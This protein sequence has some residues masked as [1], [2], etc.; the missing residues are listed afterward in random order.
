MEH[1]HTIMN[2]EI[3]LILGGIDDVVVGENYNL[4]VSGGISTKNTHI[5][6]YILSGNKSK[7]YVKKKLIEW[8]SFKEVY[9]DNGTLDTKYFVNILKTANDILPLPVYTTNFD[10]F[11]YM[12]DT[13]Y[14][15][16]LSKISNA[17][18]NT[19]D[20]YDPFNQSIRFLFMSYKVYIENIIEIF[21]KLRNLHVDLKEIIDFDDLIEKWTYI[22]LENKTDTSSIILFF[23]FPPSVLKL[24]STIP[25]I[26]W[27]INNTKNNQMYK[28][29]NKLI[30]KFLSDIKTLK[31]QYIGFCPHVSTMRLLA[32]L[33]FPIFHLLNA[34][35]ELDKISKKPQKIKNK[36][37]S[38]CKCIIKKIKNIE[39]CMSVIKTPVILSYSK[40][41]VCLQRTKFSSSDKSCQIKILEKY[42]GL[43]LHLYE[44]TLP[45]IS[46]REFLVNKVAISFSE[47][48][49]S[50]QNLAKKIY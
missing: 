11:I 5:N 39:K 40:K 32:I 45:E 9:Y 3:K 14:N 29:Y 2:P 33:K 30:D 24:D 20:I 37:N 17:L 31:F 12:A 23:N 8:D 21:V 46:K 16:D 26:K 25:T 22:D 7:T 19:Y 18:I 42:I 27:K 34:I 15:S 41:K 6:K 47:I 38:K 49:N 43:Y 10:D 35:Y 50:I 36:L 13:L 4:Q 48:S 1:Q 28:K 44:K